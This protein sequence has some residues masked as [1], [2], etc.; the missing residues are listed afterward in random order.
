M[1]LPDRFFPCSPKPIVSSRQPRNA[2]LT[3]F[4]ELVD[5]LHVANA[6]VTELGRSTITPKAGLDQNRAAPF[7]SWGKL[8]DDWISRHRLNHEILVTPKVHEL[9]LRSGLALV[10]WEAD[11]LYVDISSVSHCG[12][13]LLAICDVAFILLVVT[14]LGPH[15]LGLNFDAL[16]VG[17]SRSLGGFGEHKGEVVVRRWSGGHIE[18]GVDLADNFVNLEV[19]LLAFDAAVVD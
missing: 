11:Q 10:V 12:A 14:A 16:S 2:V 19:L 6:H 9:V 3:R 8:V 4:E 18:L 15:Q 17:V 7:N 1:E 13:D 5:A